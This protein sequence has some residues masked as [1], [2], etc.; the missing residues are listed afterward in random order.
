MAGIKSI[1]IKIYSHEAHF[2]PFGILVVLGFL[3]FMA[4]QDTQWSNE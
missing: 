4:F 2:K 3:H 1:Y